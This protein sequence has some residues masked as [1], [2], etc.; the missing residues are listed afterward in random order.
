MVTDTLP[1]LVYGALGGCVETAL[2]L[3]GSWLLYLMAARVFDDIQDGEGEGHPWNRQGLL[4][5]LPVGIGLMSTAAICLSQQQADRDTLCSLYRLFG[6]TGVGAAQAQRNERSDPDKNE[7]LES[8]F[9]HII[10]ATA[11]VFA[12]GAR[13]G[14]CLFGVGEQTLTA[15]SDFGYNLGMKLA[16]LDDCHDLT[17]GPGSSSDVV[18]GRY[19]LPVLYALAQPVTP[20]Q[21][22]LRRMLQEAQENKAVVADAVGLLDD[23]GAIAWSLNLAQVYQEKALSALSRLPDKNSGVLAAYV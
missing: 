22:Q 20:A 11:Q 18:N 3:N 8:Y 14:G 4:P 2:P 17:A 15:L 6:L 10:G 1:A 21:S 12:A 13:A 23:M 7:V 9:A 16:I 19:R 5:A